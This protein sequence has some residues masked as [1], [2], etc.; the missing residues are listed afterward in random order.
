M[1]GRKG[2]T[3]PYLEIVD[4][5]ERNVV[6]PTREKRGKNKQK[7]SRKGQKAQKDDGR[8]RGGI[9]GQVKLYQGGEK[10]GKKNNSFFEI[11]KGKERGGTKSLGIGRTKPVGSRGGKRT[12]FRVTTLVTS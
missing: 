11:G 6:S 7:V 5:Y 10:G 9:R 1:M 3:G 2:Q 4:L 12:G 8:Q